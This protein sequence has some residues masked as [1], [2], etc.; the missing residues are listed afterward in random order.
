LTATHSKNSPN[1][2][3]LRVDEAV[4][5]SQMDAGGACDEYTLAWCFLRVINN[6]NVTSRKLEDS[7]RQLYK[8]L[9]AASA[10]HH[11][12]KVEESQRTKPPKYDGLVTDG[13]LT[14][15]ELTKCIK[16]GR[17]AVEQSAHG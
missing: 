6:R 8:T 3:L 7:A 5:L 12:K 9:D 1:L 10:T 14:Q 16:R 4:E 17:S 15:D 13:V 11:K 2:G